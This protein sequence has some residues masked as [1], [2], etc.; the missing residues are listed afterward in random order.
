MEIELLAQHLNSLEEEE[1]AKQCL[2]LVKGWKN[3]L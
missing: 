1:E 2:M 3:M